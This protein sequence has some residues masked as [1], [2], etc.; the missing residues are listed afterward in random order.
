[1]VPFPRAG[2]IIYIKIR[3]F[4]QLGAGL[5]SARQL[6]DLSYCYIGSVKDQIISFRQRFN[7]IRD[8]TVKCLES[9]YQSRMTVIVFFVA[10]IIGI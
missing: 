2:H 8:S 10:S 5:A 1:M 7:S 3:P 4:V 6:M 9:S